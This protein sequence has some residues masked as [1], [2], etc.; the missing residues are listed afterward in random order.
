LFDNQHFLNQIEDAERRLPFC[1]QCG[2]PTTVTEHDQ[3]LWLECPSLAH[4]RSGLRSLL[5]LDFASL[6]TRRSIVDL[7][8]AA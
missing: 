5:S 7:P 4:G 2:R 1:E 3:A 6:H 8:A